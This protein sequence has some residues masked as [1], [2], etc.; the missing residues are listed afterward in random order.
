MAVQ[1][2]PLAGTT[3]FQDRMGGF[4][5]DLVAQGRIVQGYDVSGPLNAHTSAAID[6]DL[7]DRQWRDMF[8]QAL[9]EDRRF[10]RGLFDTAHGMVV[11]DKTV[12]GPA[13]LLELLGDSYRTKPYTVA[14]V[15]QLSAARLPLEQAFD[16]EYGMALLKTSASLAYTIAL[17]QDHG[18]IPV[19]DSPLHGK[20]LEHS[21]G[22]DGVR[23]PNDVIPRTGY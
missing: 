21:C 22:R 18:W 9:G 13:A 19:T 10:Q 11:G 20:L 2:T 4:H 15:K 5:P 23:L 7:A 17:A 1:L 8:H 16:Y 6:R 14:R 12:P 3:A